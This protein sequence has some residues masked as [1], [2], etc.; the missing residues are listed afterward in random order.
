[1]NKEATFDGSVLDGPSGDDPSIRPNQLF[2]IAEAP[3]LLPLHIASDALDVVTRTLLVPM[4]LRTLDQDDPA[5]IGRYEGG[6]ETRDGAYHEGTA[7]PW[8][9]GPFLAAQRAVHGTSNERT[10][11]MLETLLTEAEEH[12]GVAGVG[13][14]SEILD[15]LA[16]NTPR[17]CI[18]QAWSVAGLLDI[19]G[20]RTTKDGSP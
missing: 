6:P 12:L 19:I 13:S 10:T 17:G 4:G 9:L 14:V 20:T 2:A 5:F 7:W 18:A 1:M 8:L 15:A 16:P 11:A 3:D